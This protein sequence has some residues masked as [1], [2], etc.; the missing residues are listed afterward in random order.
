[1]P[2]R[3]QESQIWSTS[4]R[5]DSVDI[6]LKSLL[7]KLAQLCEFGSIEYDFNSSSSRYFLRNLE[8]TVGLKVG[9]W[10]GGEEGGFGGV[11]YMI[12]VA[13]RSGNIIVSTSPRPKQE[14]RETHDTGNKTLDI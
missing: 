6:M 13:C 2:V 5:F 11:L 14:T 4:L 1:M 8:E 10:G 3:H 9:G 7:H 12:P